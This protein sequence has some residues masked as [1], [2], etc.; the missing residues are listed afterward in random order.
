MKKTV[1][2]GAL[3]MFGLAPAIGWACSDYDDT[4]ASAAPPAKMAVAPAPAASKM[5][6]NIVKAAA[7]TPANQAQAKSKTLVPEGKVVAT[8]AN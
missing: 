7:A 5:P 3:A 2:L 4:S 8:S 1:V 6:A